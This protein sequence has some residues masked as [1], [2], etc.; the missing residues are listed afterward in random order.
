M[1]QQQIRILRKMCDPILSRFLWRMGLRV[2]RWEIGWP[3]SACLRDRSV[4]DALHKVAEPDA[5]GGE[6]RFVVLR[7]C[8]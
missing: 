1:V 3:E 2:S 7:L 8:E 4:A 5:R 6:E